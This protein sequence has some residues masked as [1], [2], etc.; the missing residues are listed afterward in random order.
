MKQ[1]QRLNTKTVKAILLSI[2]SLLIA[3]LLIFSVIYITNTYFFKDQENQGTVEFAPG[4]Y[5]D[6]KENTIKTTNVKTELNL[7]YYPNQ[8]LTLTPVKFDTQNEPGYP[9]KEYYV[10]S[11]EFKSAQNANEKSA[12]FVARCKILYTDNANIELTAENK[13]LLFSQNFA[14]AN[15]KGVL[16]EV[17]NT[18]AVGSNDYYYYTGNTEITNASSVN[19]L[20][21]ISYSENAEYIK[22][23]KTN[24]NGVAVIKL[25]NQTIENYTD[26]GIDKFHV[27]L[28]MEF[29]EVGSDT[30]TSWFE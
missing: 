7:T 14:D 23:L 15:D 13:E 12:S 8:D 9:N 10:V 3:C 21:V 1:T 4:I 25:A 19:D 30:A 27:I 5:L 17:E 28:V 26:Y 29:A 22:I 16:L 24:E 18:W 6:F 20:A 11:P 2:I